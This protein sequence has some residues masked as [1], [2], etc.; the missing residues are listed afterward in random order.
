MRQKHICRTDIDISWLAI[1]FP[2][3]R[4]LESAVI[5]RGRLRQ[6]SERPAKTNRRA[7]AG[8]D[9]KALIKRFTISFSISSS[10]CAQLIYS[11]TRLALKSA[12][13]ARQS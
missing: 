9:E 8:E 12:E 7:E 1:S 13:I 10:T 5:I 4:R 2:E 3:S 6:P 11:G